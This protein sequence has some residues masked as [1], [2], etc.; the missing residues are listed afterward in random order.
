MV[1]PKSYDLLVEKLMHKT[2]TLTPEECQA[3]VA[4]ITEGVFKGEKGEFVANIGL[5]RVPHTV[6][7]EISE[8]GNSVKMEVPHT[9]ITG[10][11]GTLQPGESMTVTGIPEQL[12][13]G[14]ISKSGRVMKSK[15]GRKKGWRKGPKEAK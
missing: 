12:I 13:P 6:K 2:T 14:Y 3:E 1:M 7:Y 9:D 10:M 8:D 4:E 11:P 15:P 5:L